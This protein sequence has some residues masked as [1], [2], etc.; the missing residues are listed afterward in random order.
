MAFTHSEK[1]G[2]Q[3]KPTTNG[4]SAPSANPAGKQEEED[5]DEID[6]DDI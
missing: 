5:D 2:M 4:T 1:V 6:L 3:E